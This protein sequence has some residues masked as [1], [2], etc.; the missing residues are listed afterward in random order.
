MREVL[1]ELAAG[2]LVV[3]AALM[4]TR[5]ISG[6]CTPQSGV[7]TPQPGCMYTPARVYVHLTPGCL[8]R[9]SLQAE[10][11]AKL[12]RIGNSCSLKLLDPVTC[13]STSRKKQRNPRPLVQYY[14]SIAVLYSNG[15]VTTPDF[16]VLGALL[17]FL[18]RPLCSRRL[19]SFVLKESSFTP[20]TAAST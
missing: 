20:P 1:H 17:F 5:T 19:C 9:L 2:A 18:R 13:F 8:Y 12:G 11:E 14:R 15:E 6:V 4:N 3:L 7:C 16:S 10:R